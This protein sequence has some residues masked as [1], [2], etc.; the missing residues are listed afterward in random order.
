M[1]NYSYVGSRSNFS[2]ISNFLILLLVQA[3]DYPKAC[4]AKQIV[5]RWREILDSHRS[6][7]PISSLAQVRLASY[8]SIGLEETFHLPPHVQQAIQESP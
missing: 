7:F 1:A 2:L 3:P 6:S 5:K 8:Y 4:I